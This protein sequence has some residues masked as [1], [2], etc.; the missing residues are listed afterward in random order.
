LNKVEQSELDE[1]R[2]LR[3][4]PACCTAVRHVATRYGVLQRGTAGCNAVRRVATRYGV[5][6]RGTA[7]CGGV[8]R[9]CLMA[10]HGKMWRGPG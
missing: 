4:Q 5:L 3:R 10:G 7:C 2:L 6:Q 9:P 8:P 1:V